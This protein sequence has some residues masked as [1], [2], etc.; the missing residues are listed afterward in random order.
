M[1]ETAAATRPIDKQALLE[2]YRTERDKRLLPEGNAQYLE[3]RGT[4]LTH[5]LEDPY[6]PFV[7]RPR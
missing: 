2:R 4:H 5:Y 7:Q 6:T 3:L 1:S